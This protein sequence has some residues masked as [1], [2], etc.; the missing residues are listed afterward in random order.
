MRPALLRGEGPQRTCRLWEPFVTEAE[1]PAPVEPSLEVG[2]MARVIL[3][4]GFGYDK[5][6]PIRL[7]VSESM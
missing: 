1:T 5:A 7:D 2:Q 3:D 4:A 6:V